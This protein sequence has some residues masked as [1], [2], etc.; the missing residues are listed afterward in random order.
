MNLILRRQRYFISFLIMVSFLASLVGPVVPTYAADTSD[1][2][3]IP[4]APVLIGPANGA[5]V[6]AVGSG[7][8]VVLAPPAAIPEFSWQSVAEATS[9]RIQIA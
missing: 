1:T 4:P 8:D 5:V 7:V 6:K 3:D 9:Y 2:A